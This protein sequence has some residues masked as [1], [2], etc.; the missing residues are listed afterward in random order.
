M[1]LAGLLVAGTLTVYLQAARFGYMTVDDAAY[2]FENVHVQQG[3]TWRGIVWSFTSIHDS[4]WIPFTWLSLMLDSDLY[5]VRPGGY[6]FTNILLH[7]ANSVLLFAMLA[8]AT[9]NALRSAFVAALFAIHPLHVESVAWI[10]ERKDVLSTFFGLLSLLMYLRY[11]R[12]ADDG[13]SLF[14]CYFL[15]PACCPSRRS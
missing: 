2:A 8:Y 5:G 13:A 4:N 9:G 3:I 14:P 10:A 6:H 11:A 12:E 15:L 7:A 1:V